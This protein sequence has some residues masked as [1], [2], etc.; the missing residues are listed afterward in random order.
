MLENAF[1]SKRIKDLKKRYPIFIYILL[2]A[3]FSLF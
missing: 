2:N 1:Q 3:F